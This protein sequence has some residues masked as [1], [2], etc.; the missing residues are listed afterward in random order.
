M[1][2][3]LL[4]ALHKSDEAQTQAQL[5]SDLDPLNP[6]I[7]T[8]FSLALLM[9]GD[10]CETATAPVEKVLAIE[11]ENF[12]ANIILSM[13]AFRCG[14][15]D[16]VIEAEKHILPVYSRGQFEEDAFI[17]IERIFD[18]QGFS[19][20]YEEIL[21]QWEVLDDKGFVAPIDMAVFYIRGN[22]QDKAMDC[23]EKGYEVRDPN[24]AYLATKSYTLDSLY[25][26]PRF[27][28]ILEKLNLPLPDN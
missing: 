6:L 24:M 18:K 28:A 12:I 16:K 14:D 3:H 11:P 23:L 22:Q 20:A 4:C 21:H 9:T 15:Y 10:D 5:A 19:A 2:A 8:M 7:Q 27:I 1:Y 25:D 26:N 17:E 13:V